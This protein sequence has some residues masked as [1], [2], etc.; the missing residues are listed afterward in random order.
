[1]TLPWQRLSDREKGVPPTRVLHEG[2]PGHLEALLR[3]WVYKAL[4]G[5]EAERVALRLEIRID[6]EVAQNSGALF[7]ARS[8][9]ACELLD[10]IDAILALGGPWPKNPKIVPDMREGLMTLLREG[11]SV[12]RVND[13]F[14]GLIRRV[15]ATV[16]AAAAETESAASARHT[17]GSAA[18]QLAAAWDAAYRL[19]PDPPAA[20]RD[21]IRAV[22]SAAHAIIEPNNRRATLGTM[23]RQ[24]VGRPQRYAL[25]IPGPDGTGSIDPLIGMIKLL[26]EGQT[27]RHGAQ[28]TTRS[29]TLEEARMAVHL[30]VTLVQWFTTD[31]VRRVP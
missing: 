17:A 13:D 21:A 4:E 12:W 10:V 27:S 24:L 26:W 7:L 28:T 6:Y 23:L 8:T 30:A 20:Y 9:Q 3:G 25:A 5:G 18:S 22:E 16:A 31:A 15:D 19:H 29:E 1:V 11:S 14:T 2:V